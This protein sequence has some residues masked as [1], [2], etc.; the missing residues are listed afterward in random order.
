LAR[1]NSL[2]LF[3]VLL[4]FRLCAADLVKVNEGS[5]ISRNGKIYVVKKTSYLIAV[6]DY[7]KKIEFISNVEDQMVEFKKTIRKLSS[8]TV[9]LRTMNRRLIRKSKQNLKIKIA[10]FAVAVLGQEMFKGVKF[11]KF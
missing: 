7:D 9:K 5:V 6:E 8:D 3:I 2:I 1:Y 4:S 11:P 10:L